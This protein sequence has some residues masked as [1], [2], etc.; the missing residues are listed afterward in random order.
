M[1]RGRPNLVKI[2][3]M[4][5]HSERFRDECTRLIQ[6]TNRTCKH[7]QDDDN[8]HLDQRVR[9]IQ[10]LKKELELKLE[11]TVLEIDV[12]IELQIRVM[13]ALEACKEPLRVT[14]LCLEERKKRL[15]SEMLH[16]EVDA[17]L[18]REKETIEGVV[19]LLQPVVEQ[20]TE[21]IR[22]NR[23]TKYLL[24]ED[25]KEK[26]EAECVDNSCTLMISHSINNQQRSKNTQN[27]LPKSSSVTPKQWEQIS[28]RNIAKAEQQKSNSLSLRV[29]VES[30]LKQTSA[31]MQRQVQTTTD[32]FQRNVREIQAAKSQMEDELVQI[33]SETTSQ[34]Q[35]Q[36]DLLV[37]ITE[38]E[39]FLSL[40]KAK[41]AL[42]QQRPAKEQCHDSAQ[43]QLLVEVQQVTAQISRLHAA[44][45]QSEK[46]QRGL[47]RCQLELQENIKLK[48][49]SLYI[50]EVICAQHREP[51]IIHNF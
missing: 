47:I 1:S 12:L 9:D 36:E 37:A 14:V 38:A 13:N 32:A 4:R 44:V 25:L 22:L 48:A 27:V 39:H 35:V 29:L 18:Q 10:F 45:A 3:N 50:D 40:A 51:I 46:E 8:K 43:C 16:D 24:E 11:E 33:L 34:Q 6:E 49:S 23:S 26:S 20:I 15:S 19:S 30:L 7:M 2:D 17:E 21:Q 42:R 41:L 5:N 28:N 31:D